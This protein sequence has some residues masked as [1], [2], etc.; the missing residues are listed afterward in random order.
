MT[1]AAHTAR[2]ARHPIKADLVYG[3]EA[4]R[5]PR[6]SEKGYIADLYAVTIEGK[7]FSRTT[8]D[9]NAFHHPAAKWLPM[10]DL[11]EAVSYVGTYD[12]AP[13]RA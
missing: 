9:P 4:I 13:I 5:S 12:A 1:N 11:P 10:A 3:Y 8:T 2:T 6:Y 7:V